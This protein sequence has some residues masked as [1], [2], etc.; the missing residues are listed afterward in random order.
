MNI[1]YISDK[2][3]GNGTFF[4]CNNIKDAIDLFYDNYGYDPEVI[5]KIND[6]RE[7]VLIKD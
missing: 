7:N 6:D 3:T 1:Y 5:R 2:D 4:V